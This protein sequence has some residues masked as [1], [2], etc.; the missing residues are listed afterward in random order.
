MAYEL[1]RGVVTLPAAADLSANQ[2]C[3]VTVNSS[4]QAALAGA[5]ALAIGVIQ[6]K[7]TSGTSTAIAFDGISKVLVGSGGTVTAGNNVTPD[8]SG[9]AAVAT[10]GNYVAGVAL[11]T[12]AAG[13][14][15]AVLLTSA[16]KV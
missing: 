13:T 9:A 1:L 15:I 14:L 4:S 5:G 7:P 6:N 3:F 10:T 16:G 2:F 12:G 11:E 8:A